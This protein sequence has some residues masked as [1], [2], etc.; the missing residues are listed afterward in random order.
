MPPNGRT[1][2]PNQVLVGHVACLGHGGGGHARL[3]F[4][5]PALSNG[6]ALPSRSVYDN[7]L[8]TVQE[9]IAPE[10]ISLPAWR[11]D[12]C[13]TAVCRTLVRVSGF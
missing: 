2:G 4:D 6:E 1:L 5:D 11:A 7:T 13:R 9:R 12:A 3:V 8:V 10:L